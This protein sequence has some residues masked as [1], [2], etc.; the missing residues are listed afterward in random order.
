MNPG[1]LP[2][3]LLPQNIGGLSK[4]TEE[5]EEISQ[6][7]PDGSVCKTML[8]W[9]N[10]GKLLKNNT[11]CEDAPQVHTDRRLQLMFPLPVDLPEYDP[12][13]DPMA[14]TWVLGAVFLE[15]FVVVLDFEHRRLGIAEPSYKF[16][17]SHSAAPVA[18]VPDTTTMEPYVA[19]P[20]SASRRHVGQ[21]F[22]HNPDPNRQDLVPTVHAAD[23]QTNGSQHESF[24]WGV[25]LLGVSLLTFGFAASAISRKMRRRK[26]IVQNN[27]DEAEGSAD[28]ELRVARR[29]DI[30]DDNIEAAE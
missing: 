14:N 13:L 21:N 19:K 7:R 27:D 18:S 12:T 16:A 25:P 1:L 8:T 30:G 6:T 20:S 26:I 17:Y 23:D 2:P 3:F 4:S 11:H 10:H 15:Q 5:V 24:N 28:E 22:R 9:D 29:T